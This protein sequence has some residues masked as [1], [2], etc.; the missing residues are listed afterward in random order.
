MLFAQLNDIR[1]HYR[2][3]GDP[4][5]PCVVLSNSL[6]TDLHMWDAQA[7]ALAQHYH[8]V[9]YDSRGHGSSDA[10]AGPA[11]L[12]RLGQDVLE[13][14]DHLGIAQAHF[15]GISMGGMTGQWLG[16]V[17]P[18]RIGKLVLANTAAR[19]GSTDGWSA[20]AGLVRRDGMD[21][22]A[23]GA[24]ERWFSPQFIERQPAVVASMIDTLR[25]QDP[26][27]YA[28]CCDALAQA[29]LRDTVG[30]IPNRTLV[31]AG[32][33]DPVTTVADAEWLAQQIADASVLTLPASHLSNIEASHEFSAAVLQFL[34]A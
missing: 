14:L 11:T 23:D 4:S 20:R 24:A 30:S 15:C 17:A 19:I 16:I 27:G 5:A 32:Q 18:Q 10:G 26:A 28:S 13:L 12:E 21:A 6:G 9:R 29:D 1:L 7:D 22:V 8:V 2:T 25:R 3:D 34:A 33:Y 31:V